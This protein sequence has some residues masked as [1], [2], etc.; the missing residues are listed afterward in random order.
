[1]SISEM[2]KILTPKDLVKIGIASGK[3]LQTWRSKRIG[4]KFVRLDTGRV[5]YIAEDVENWLRQ[6]SSSCILQE[7][8]WR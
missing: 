7:T 2:K 5:R 8:K 3:S 1:M 4:P 6:H